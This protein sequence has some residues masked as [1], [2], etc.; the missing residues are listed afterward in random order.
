MSDGD[1][2]L[3]PR[4]ILRA[5]LWSAVDGRVL[6]Y[7]HKEQIL[8]AMKAIWGDRLVLSSHVRGITLMTLITHCRIHQLI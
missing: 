5:G 1:A 7:I 6:V 4:K 8:A 3:Q 2:V